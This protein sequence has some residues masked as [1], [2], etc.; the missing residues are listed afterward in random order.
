M[1]ITL[2]H[3]SGGEES[4]RLIKD[5][6][7][8][9][10]DDEILLKMEDSAVLPP[11]HGNPVLTSDSFVVEPLFFKGGD[12]GKLSVCG[13]VNDL[14]SMGARPLYLTASFILETG[15]DTDILGKIVQSMKETAEEAGVRIVAGDTK[16]IEGKGGLYINT[17]GMSSAACWASQKRWRNMKSG[18]A[19]ILTGTLGDHHAAV[20]TNRLGIESGIESDC[21]P[22]NHMVEELL[23]G[24]ISVHT[25]RD[26]TRGGLATVANELAVASSVR[27]DLEEELIPVSDIVQGF[28][29]ILG[30]DPLTMGNEGK[31][32]IAVSPKDAEK[33]VGILRRNKYGR[34]AVA[35]GQVLEGKGVYLRTALGGLRR[36]LPLRG[37]GLPRIC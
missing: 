30:L 6:F 4:G 20:L 37:E 23:E 5:I 7:T 19:L 29:G 17:A 1:K 21:A 10:F 31:M 13:T 22:L 26:I 18:D 32:I 36:V 35:A 34:N 27:I 12:I 14:S 11:L 2:K 3:G 15:L 28:T 8:S 9:V 16:V 33:A 24:N 25:V